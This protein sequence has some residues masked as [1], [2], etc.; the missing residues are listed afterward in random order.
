MNKKYFTLLVFAVSLAVL[1]ILALV[2][3]QW[4]L[5]VTEQ[6]NYL[7][8]LPLILNSHS[9]S[10]QPVVPTPE[11]GFTEQ[12]VT[13]V[14]Q[15]RA[16]NGCGAV[17]MDERLRLAAQNH[18]QD[19]GLNDYFSHTGL[20]G[21]SPWDRILA[22]GYSYSQAGENIAV[23]YSS[24]ESV[25]NAWMNSTQGHRENILDCNFVHI[26]MGYFYLANDTGNVNYNHYWT[27]VF[28]S[29]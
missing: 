3:Q 7:V 9:P 24:P 19:M 17:T 22:Q 8:Y 18:S 5:A 23:G 1:L 4:G 13:L 28:A 27:Q 11:P 26:G 10:S 12:V 2:P 21:S 15:E 6:G 29:P 20:N 16:A 14:N 25:V